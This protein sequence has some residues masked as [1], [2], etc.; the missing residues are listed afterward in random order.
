MSSN[1]NNN[2]KLLLITAD[3]HGELRELVWKIV[4][5]HKLRSVNLI[6][7]GDLGVGFGR[8]KSID[9]L[10]S[11]IEKKLEK[12]DLTIYSIRGNH[13]NPKYFD[14]EHDFERLKFLK[15]YKTVEINGLKILPIGGAV[16]IDQ[17]GRKSYNS[18]MEKN[19][20]AK[21]SWWPDEVVKELT[22]EEFKLLPS[23]VDLVISHCAPISFL[24]VFSRTDNIELEVWRGILKE[25]NYL[26]KIKNNL[27][28]RYWFF[29]HYHQSVSG[30]FGDS[31]YRGLSI[32][33][34]YEFLAYEENNNN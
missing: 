14:G 22:D 24:P 32:M 6:V 18:K 23:R 16:S 28:F 13:D 8:P 2:D 11:R 21:R 20:S 31:L 33:E 15:D 7:C 27:W 3:P 30:N 29:G 9:H 19:H 25:R 17:A 34:L 1:D 12:N 4:D 10:Y 26:E 5:Q